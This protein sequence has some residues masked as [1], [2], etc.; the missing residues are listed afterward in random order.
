VISPAAIRQALRLPADA[1]QASNFGLHG[2]QPTRLECRDG[3][4]LY[5]EWRFV[6]PFPPGFLLS[7]SGE[8]P[9]S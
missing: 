8:E 7:G 3:T 2:A 1:P 9:E 6:N 5:V 4:G